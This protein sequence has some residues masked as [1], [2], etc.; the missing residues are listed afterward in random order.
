M[1]RRR[2]APPP[3]STP[4]TTITT[5]GLPRPEGRRPENRRPEGRPTG[6]SICGKRTGSLSYAA[7]G[8]TRVL[9]L[10]S[11]RGH[12]SFWLAGSVVSSQ[13]TE[14]IQFGKYSL[15]ELI[16][17]GGMAEG[18]LQGADPGLLPP[19]SSGRSWSRGSCHRISPTTRPSSRCSS[20]RAKLSAPPRPPE[21][22]PHLRA[23][24]GRRRV[25]HLDGVHPRARPLRDDARHLEDDG[26]APARDGRLHRPRGPAGAFPTRTASPTR[27]GSSGDGPPRDISPSNVMLSYEG[28]SSCST[29]G[30][31]RRSATRR[32]SPRAAP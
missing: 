20:R 17:R 27:T 14:P 31:P 22:R 16:G 21:H 5:G 24:R 29:S 26:A 10:P 30:S 8:K 25:L 18:S 15:F 12:A 1:S 19:G 13:L 4:P 9:T 3:G 11:L 23:G 2:P 32:R 28:R 6:E 7:P